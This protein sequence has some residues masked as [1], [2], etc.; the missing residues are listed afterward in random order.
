MPLPFS[1]QHSALKPTIL[2]V[3]VAVSLLQTGVLV[4]LVLWMLVFIAAPAISACGGG[5]LESA[6]RNYSLASNNVSGVV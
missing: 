2:S 4:R 3:S 6:T 1:A 5:P